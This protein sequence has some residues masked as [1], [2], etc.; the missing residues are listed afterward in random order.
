[1]YDNNEVASL[2]YNKISLMLLDSPYKKVSSSGLNKVGVVAII[3]TIAAIG[4]IAVQ[5]RPQAQSVTVLTQEDPVSTSSAPL[6][7]D[8][9]VDIQGVN[10]NCRQLTPE[11]WALAVNDFQ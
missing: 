7:T 2:K 10:A 8:P 9:L 3:G 4:M 5:Y 1:L 6:V 11:N